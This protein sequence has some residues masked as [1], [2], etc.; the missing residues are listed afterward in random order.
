MEPIEIT[1]VLVRW[2]HLS[3]VVVAI[4]GAVFMRFVLMPAAHAALSDDAKKQLHPR[5][6]GRWKHFVHVN[7]TLLF[8]TGAFN[9]YMAVRDGVHPM[10]Y[11]AILTV[12]LILALTVFF[13]AIALTGTG[14]GFAKL[15]AQRAKWMTV[16]V[17]LA[18]IIILLSGVLKAVH[19]SAV[20]S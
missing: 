9:I 2:I 3:A 7:V 11:H 10:P 4:G 6:V 20:A 17:V 1:A 14:P 15:R 12:K 19:F 18:A 13:L 5:L 8:L 16:F